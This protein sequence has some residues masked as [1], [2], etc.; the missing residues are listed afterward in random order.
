MRCL[1]DIPR[2]RLI[3]ICC[4][5]SFRYSQNVAVKN[6]LFSQEALPN[7][8]DRADILALLR[9]CNY[10]PDECIGTYLLLDGD[11]KYLFIS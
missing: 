6:M 7:W 5:M 3:N 11:G 1:S 2:T 8:K 10:S 9:F 4:D